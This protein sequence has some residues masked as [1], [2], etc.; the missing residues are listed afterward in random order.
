[1][2]RRAPI[3][4]RCWAARARTRSGRDRI[5]RDGLWRDMAT[6]LDW[7]A[8][9]RE[10]PWCEEG[11]DVRSETTSTVDNKTPLE[12]GCRHEACQPDT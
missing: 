2:T 4:L 9:V 10:A 5:E 11:A 8:P 7:A 1:M 3:A 12:R 6:L